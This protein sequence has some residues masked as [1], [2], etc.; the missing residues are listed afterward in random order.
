MDPI[1]T[2]APDWHL[3]AKYKEYNVDL[4]KN[5]CFTVSMQKINSIH[6]LTLYIQQI[7]GSHDLNYHAHF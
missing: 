7:L 4:T 6:K 2:A 3:K 5:Y 1:N